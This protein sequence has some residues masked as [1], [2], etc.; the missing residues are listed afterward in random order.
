MG[1]DEIIENIDRVYRQAVQISKDV[2]V[3]EG[4]TDLHTS[5][6]V[7]TTKV[8]E[9]KHATIKREQA[10]S[11]KKKLEDK[12]KEKVEKEKKRHNKLVENCKLTT[13][14]YNTALAD[15]VNAQKDLILANSAVSG[16]VQYLT[17]KP[18]S[19]KYL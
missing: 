15:V 13:E 16:R 18:Y 7:L 1:C 14:K 11:K 6:R 3:M 19:S 10:D 2:Q 5:T 17:S 9:L 12:G 8:E 4:M